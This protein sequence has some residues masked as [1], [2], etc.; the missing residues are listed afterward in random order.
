MKML[1]PTTNVT[2]RIDWGYPSIAFARGEDRRED[3]RIGIAVER[4][5]GDATKSR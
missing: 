3:K 5:F 4:L 1:N 2:L